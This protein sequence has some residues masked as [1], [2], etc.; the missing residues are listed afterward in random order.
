MTPGQIGAVLVIAFICGVVG[1]YVG[2]PKGRRTAGFFLGF[3]LSVIGILIVVTLPATHEAQVKA[4]ADR[5]RVEEEARRQV[6]WPHQPPGP[7]QGGGQ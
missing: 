2:K 4:A 6:G 3:F 1:E 7:W 5:L